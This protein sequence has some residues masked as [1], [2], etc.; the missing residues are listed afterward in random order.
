M[1]LPGNI[2]TVVTLPLDGTNLQHLPKADC[3]G[4]KCS[5]GMDQYFTEL[6]SIIVNKDL[7]FICAVNNNVYI[8]FRITFRYPVQ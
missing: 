8:C 2:P 5:Q 6:V 1:P 3:S 4:N 7:L